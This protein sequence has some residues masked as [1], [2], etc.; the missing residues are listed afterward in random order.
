LPRK[1]GRGARRQTGQP[2]RANQQNLAPV[3]AHETCGMYLGRYVAPNWPAAEFNP[4]LLGQ[5]FTVKCGTSFLVPES[6][7]RF[8]KDVLRGARGVVRV[9]SNRNDYPTISASS[10]LRHFD[11][12]RSA[13]NPWRE[14]QAAGGPLLLQWHVESFRPCPCRQPSRRWRVYTGTTTAEVNCCWIP[15]VFSF[16]VEL[17]QKTQRS[18]KNALCPKA[19]NSWWGSIKAPSVIPRVPCVG[20]CVDTLTLYEINENQTH[21]TLVSLGGKACVQNTEYIR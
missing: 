13:K 21:E 17:D 15:A 2:G 9:C 7:L 6:K 16:E 12:W 14:R 20:P 8:E 4:L 18:K 3:L 10:A 5:Q 1:L 19:E 11:L